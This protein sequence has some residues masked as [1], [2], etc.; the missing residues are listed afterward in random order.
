MSAKIG[1]KSPLDQFAIKR[2]VLE[3][4]FL[5]WSLLFVPAKAGIQKSWIPGRAS[6]R[7]LAR[8]DDT[9]LLGICLPHLAS[10]VH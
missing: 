7:Q 10:A 9:S 2:T 8:N 3:L 1:G 6:Y 5:A 4:S